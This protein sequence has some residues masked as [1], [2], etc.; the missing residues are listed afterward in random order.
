MTFIFLDTISTG[1]VIVIMLFILVFFGADSIP[2]IARTLG[3]SI[4]QVKDAT[5]DIQRE[6]QDSVKDSAKEIRKIENSVERSFKETKK[7]VESNF[8]EIEKPLKDIKI[9]K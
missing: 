5:Q 2:K 3:R 9:E 4:R 6:I 1:E 8:K 7:E